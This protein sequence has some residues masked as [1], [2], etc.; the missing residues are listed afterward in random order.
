M[1]E[2]VEEWGGWRGNGGGGEG[3]GRGVVWRVGNGRES[4]G[5]G[6]D[7]VVVVVDR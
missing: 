6:V 5:K 7:G 3:M 1:G 4:S 2:R